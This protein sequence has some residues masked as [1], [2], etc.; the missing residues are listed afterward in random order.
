MS[1]TSSNLGRTSGYTV[2]RWA[3]DEDERDAQMSW[4]DNSQ[5]SLR[6]D[7]GSYQ[8]MLDQALDNARVDPQAAAAE[9]ELRSIHGCSTSAGHRA[10]P[11]SGNRRRLGGGTSSGH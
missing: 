3:N 10:Y 11:P 5:Y 6:E 7:N 2:S 8:G 4:Y 9:E 1:P